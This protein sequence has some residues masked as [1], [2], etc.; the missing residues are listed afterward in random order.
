MIIVLN[1]DDCEEEKV[2]PIIFKGLQA[3]KYGYLERE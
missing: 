2:I 3:D 1:I